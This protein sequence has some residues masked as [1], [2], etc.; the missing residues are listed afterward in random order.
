MCVALTATECPFKKAA[1]VRQ[2][3]ALVLELEPEVTELV[4]DWFS[5]GFRAPERL[6]TQWEDSEDKR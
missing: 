4:E 2:V 3:K 5:S 6:I 1:A